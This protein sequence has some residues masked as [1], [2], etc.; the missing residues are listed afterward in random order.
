MV[1]TAGMNGSDLA[2]WVEEAAGEERHH[3]IRLGFA[4]DGPESDAVSSFD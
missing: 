4:W 1:G 3:D 2:D